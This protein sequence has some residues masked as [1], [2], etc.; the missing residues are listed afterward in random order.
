MLKVNCL[1]LKPD[2]H[3]YYLILFLRMISANSCKFLK[4]LQELVGI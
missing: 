1:T 3:K 4:N 2:L